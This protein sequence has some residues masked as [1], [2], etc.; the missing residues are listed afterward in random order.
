MKKLFLVVTLLVVVALSALFAVPFI[1]N[2]RDK[3][4]L[5]RV[6]ENLPVF[7]ES[8]ACAIRFRPE[9]VMNEASVSCE[10]VPIY[11]FD[12]T[13]EKYDMHLKD[14]GWI[15][16]SKA[17]NE[18]AFHYEKDNYRLSIG[19]PSRIRASVIHT[20]ENGEV[21]SWPDESRKNNPNITVGVGFK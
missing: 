14:S 8:N 18:E 7:S 11:G 20:D 1:Q 15:F 12:E 17:Q 16:Y 4:S 3:A 6:F 9:S 21:V 19:I 10:Y 13:I 5:T 2:K